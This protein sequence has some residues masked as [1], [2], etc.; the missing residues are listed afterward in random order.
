M[1]NQLTGTEGRPSLR[2]IIHP[3]FVPFSEKCSFMEQSNAG[4]I[5]INNIPYEVSRAEIFAFLGRSANTL[6]DRNEPIH[7]LMDRTTSKTNECYVEFASFDEAVTAVTRYQNAIDNNIHV[8]K[9]GSRDV[10]VTISSQAMLMKKLFPIAKG[11][12]WEEMPFRIIRNAPHSWDNFTGFITEEEMTL[13]CKHVE[14]YNNPVFSK[15]CPERAYECMISTVKKY[16]WHMP[17]HITIKERDCMYDAGLRM[18][19]QLQ[20]RI[21]KGEKPERLT[22]QLLSRLAEAIL[23][24]P[25][26]SISQKD[27]VAYRANMPEHKMRDLGQPRFAELWRHLQVLNTKEGVPLDIIEYYIAVVREET[28]RIADFQGISQQ[29]RLLAEQR[30]TSNYWGFF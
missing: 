15:Q 6:I 10:E 3:W 22:P 26:F 23:S 18:V 17:E 5:R 2:D 13:L 14:G 8:P 29:Q 21:S 7:I 11:V 9:I 25:G 19:G 1:L 28:T 30:S 24:C 20:R 12:L 27:N 4:V 16:P